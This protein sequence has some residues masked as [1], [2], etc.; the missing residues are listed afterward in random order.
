[1]DKKN[2]LNR[3]K[4]EKIIRGDGETHLIIRC[5]SLKPFRVQDP[6]YSSKQEALPYKE[7]DTILAKL[8]SYSE[9]ART[10]NK[11]K[12]VKYSSEDHMWRGIIKATGQLVATTKDLG[13]KGNDDVIVDCGIY[14]YAFDRLKKKVKVG[15]YVE[16]GNISQVYVK[17]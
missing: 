16:L 11:R 9:I 8:V 3:C 17:K 5:G 12:Y 10:D 1:M 15:E 14:V 2:L 7:E 6:N 4:I 13:I